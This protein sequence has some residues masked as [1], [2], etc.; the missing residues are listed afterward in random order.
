VPARAARKHLSATQ[1]EAFDEAAA[2]VD[3]H[4]PL[5]AKLREAPELLEGGAFSFEPS[6][7]FLSRL[8]S[9]SAKPAP[10]K[11]KRDSK[12]AG[13]DGASTKAADDELRALV[14]KEFG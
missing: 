12:P 3:E 9:S 2:F 11:S 5:I 14:E 13:R 8:L 1:T 10:P 6:R 4:H 7:G